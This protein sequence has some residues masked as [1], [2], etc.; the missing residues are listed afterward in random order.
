MIKKLINPFYYIAGLKSLALGLAIIILSSTIGYFS[1][2]HFPSI[3]S[4]KTSPDMPLWYFI[5]QNL[6]NWLTISTFMYIAAIL[7]SK[8]KVRIIDIYG[9]QALAR[10]PYFPAAFIGFSEALELFGKYILWT[11]LKMGEPVEISNIEIMVAVTLIVFSLLL[12]IWLI[13]LMFNAF[14]ISANI[15]GSKLSIIFIIVLV[16]SVIITEYLNYQFTLK[17]Y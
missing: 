16:I 5:I 12:T 14:K 3:I 2:T 17:L 13:A 11:T 10:Y 8:S 7:F 15:K 9:T 1:H 4:I 6:I